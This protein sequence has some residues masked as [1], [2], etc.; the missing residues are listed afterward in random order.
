V[1]P[2]LASIENMDYNPCD[3][4]GVTNYPRL[5]LYSGTYFICS[6]TIPLIVDSTG[7]P[8][9]ET[10]PTLTPVCTNPIPQIPTSVG[11]CSN[12]AFTN[13]LSLGES[14]T[15]IY[16]D[17]DR[18]NYVMT[19]DSSWDS[20]SFSICSFH[21]PTF[22]SG[23]PTNNVFQRLLVLQND[24]YCGCY[25][26]CASGFECIPIARLT[27]GIDPDLTEQWEL[28]LCGGN[29]FPTLTTVQI[30]IN[31]ANSNILGYGPA[32]TACTANPF[33]WWTFY[34]EQFTFNNCANFTTT[35]PLNIPSPLD[36]IPPGFTTGEW[37]SI[38]NPNIPI[39]NLPSD[40]LNIQVQIGSS[41]GCSNIGFA[42]ESCVVLRDCWTG[43]IV[44]TG[45][46]MN[47]NYSWVE[48]N[49]TVDNLGLT[50][51]CL[52]LDVFIPPTIIQGIDTS[53]ILKN[54]TY[55][56][57]N[58]FITGYTTTGCN[59]CLNPTPSPTTTPTPTPTPFPLYS[60]SF[61]T[62]SA[63]FLTNGEFNAR[64][65]SNVTIYSSCSIAR[66]ILNPNSITGSVTLLSS[67][68]NG[69]LLSVSDPST[70]KMREFSINAVT[71]NGISG[72]YILQITP[73]NS[74][75]LTS[76]NFDLVVGNTYNVKFFKR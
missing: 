56:D 57:N 51:C 4:S 11:T 6:L 33:E 8:Y 69:D 47:D 24:D 60:W 17:C 64:N 71:V 41:C 2:D 72:S 67:L 73:T 52:Y 16:T 5:P 15:F 37:G 48:N 7:G 40:F 61:T 75:C 22:I 34:T 23:S 31:S 21:G 44:Y 14:V 9:V 26:G 46:I 25:Y 1:V 39:F 54:Y 45:T 76:N 10:E 53:Q 12:W 28:P 49:Y 32:Y 58:G 50:D 65:S 70:S 42:S 36:T 43:N 13:N 19:V 35:Y 74:N 27:S 59:V 55:P 3:Q 62:K 38:V 63:A 18:F 29:N 68:S 30:T 66:L 20:S